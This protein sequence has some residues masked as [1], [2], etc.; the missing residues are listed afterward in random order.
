M[1]SAVLGV[2]AK[3]LEWIRLWFLLGRTALEVW[4]IFYF[5]MSRRPFRDVSIRPIFFWVS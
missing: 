2:G 4:M 3:G 1:V 5:G